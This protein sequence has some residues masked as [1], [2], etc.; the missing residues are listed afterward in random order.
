MPGSPTKGRAGTA[1]K[2]LAALIGV[3]G[4]LAAGAYAAGVH[5]PSERGRATDSSAK[6]S[7][8]V[9]RHGANSHHRAR[10]LARPKIL[11]HPAKTSLG[12]TAFF[13]I[14][15][16]ARHARLRCRLDRRRWKRCRRK[17]RYRGLA[18]GRHRFRV[19]AVSRR[20]APSR[21]RTY[22]WRVVAVRWQ[23][24]TPMPFSIAQAGAIQPLY[25]GANPSPIPLVLD[26]PNAV[27]IF[28]TSL[29]V[30]VTA[31]PPGCD[32]ATNLTLI[33][34]SASSASPLAIPARGSASLP[35]P[36]VS[37]PAIA[38]VDL[39]VNQDGCKDAQFSLAFHGSAHG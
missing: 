21:V 35:A 32:A 2:A 20:R 27:P 12:R 23:V 16:R 37:A 10:R 18:L 24:T 28:V 30:E 3:A 38:L 6:V 34:S 5:L 15:N 25:P 19:R 7:A 33:P 4:C 31:A 1:C 9:V 26:N 14:K 36:G 29:T 22:R 39:P 17:V 11:V 8:R 13:K